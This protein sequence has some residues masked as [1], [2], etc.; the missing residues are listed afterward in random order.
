MEERFVHD[1]L[2]QEVYDAYNHFIFSKDS[3]LFNKLFSKKFFVDLTRDIPGD[4][5]E[6]GV[7]KGSGFVAWLKV[8]RMAHVKRRVLGFDFFDSEKL[9]SGIKTTDQSLMASLFTARNFEPKGYE[10]VL[11]RIVQD[12]GFTNFDLIAGDVFTTIPNFLSS[13]PGFRASVINFDL[14][15]AEPTLFTLHQLWDRLVNGGVLI[16]DEY[17]INEWTE[18]DA[19]DDFIRNKGLR[20]RYTNIDAPTAYLVKD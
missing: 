12:I 1:E 13:N 2:P 18:S 8:C 6:L 20:L 4:I 15:T 7:F 9:V 10:H 5:V 11:R 3:K 19:V 17:A 14:D 16:F